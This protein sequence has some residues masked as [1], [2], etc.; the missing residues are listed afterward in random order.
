MCKVKDHPGI[1]GKVTGFIITF[2]VL[3]AIAIGLFFY[4]GSKGLEE[5][6]NYMLIAFF[7]LVPAGLV[8]G[9]I[10]L[11]NVTCPDCGGHTK[12]I[13]NK[14][15]DM[16]QAYCAKCDTTWNLGLGTNVDP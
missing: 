10:M 7:V 9:F 2:G 8:G 12:T 16:W 11:Y 6:S 15:A 3:G 14:E 5:V 1:G 13:K 4:L